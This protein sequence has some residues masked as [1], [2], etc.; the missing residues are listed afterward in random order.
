MERRCTGS[1]G[2]P[3][4]FAP[5]SML[6]RAVFFSFLLAL[7]GCGADSTVW[8]AGEQKIIEKWSAANRLGG[9]TVRERSP[10]TPP[11][12]ARTTIT[13]VATGDLKGWITSTLLFPRRQPTGLSHLTP[14]IGQLRE[15]DPELVLLDAGDALRGAPGDFRRPGISNLR[16]PI[17]KLMNALRFDAMALGNFDLPLG[18]E[19]LSLTREQSRFPWLSANLER[20]GG[21]T[22]LPPYRVLERKGVRIG[23]LAMTTP[24]AAATLNPWH[25]RGMRLSSLEAAARRWV[26]VLRLVERADLVIGLFHAGLDDD[27]DREVILRSGAAIG[28]GAGKLADGGFG[29]DLIVSGDAHRLSP[30]RSTVRLDGRAVPVLEPGARGNGLAVAKLEL[31][32]AG[33]RWRVEEVT[34]HT[35]AA[36]PAGASLP[37]GVRAALRRTGA[38]LDEPT[39]VRFRRIPRRGEFYRCAGALSH[40]AAIGHS[41]GKTETAFSLLPMRWRFHRPPKTQQGR[42]VRRADLYR[43]MAFG[44]T[45]VR[46]SLTGRQ[47]A[48]LLDGYVR[49]RRKWKVPYLAVLWPGGMEVAIAPKGS[50]I[51]AL[52]RKA[53]GRPIRP[54]ERYP[55]WLTA[56]IW[57]GGGGLAPRALIR[58]EQWRGEQPG[59]LREALFAMLRDP[60]FAVPPVCA[61]WMEKFP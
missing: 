42:S 3:P 28:G 24:R 36:H 29:F 47:I 41:R 37:G 44:E 4:G 45:L 52:G 32:E 55:V 33:G 53:T 14:V 57:F 50:E 20:E 23:V 16:F 43:W 22:V 54:H 8:D 6:A 30:R 1:L 51:T 35:L 61:R 9:L 48:L 2:P 60:E 19:V 49:H 7:T 18:W 46:A 34:R 59:T 5:G 17:V 12:G 39:G 21:G 31:A 26:P 10:S 56:F 40:R 38:W 15:G 27:F 25:L 13:V 11:V 58:P